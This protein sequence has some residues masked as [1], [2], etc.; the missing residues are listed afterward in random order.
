MKSPHKRR[1][2]D[3]LTVI[4]DG[5]KALTIAEA[6]VA[7]NTTPVALKKRLRL[8]RRRDPAPSV[9]LAVLKQ[10]QEKYRPRPRSS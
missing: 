6:A 7:L 9:T 1:R 2:S 4:T 5:D 8:R 3:A 10:D